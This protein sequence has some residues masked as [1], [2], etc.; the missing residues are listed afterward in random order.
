MA[1]LQTTANGQT[2][3]TLLCLAALFERLAHFVVISLLALHLNERRGYSEPDAL[4]VCGLYGAA[5]YVSAI[6]GGWVSDRSGNPRLATQIG[7]FLLCGGYV[8]LASP[9]LPIVVP[10]ALLTCGHALYKPSLAVLFGRLRGQSAEARFRLLY[11]TVNV[12]ATLA[13]FAAQL[14]L[15]RGGA[16]A[17]FVLANLLSVVTL[18]TVLILSKMPDSVSEQTASRESAQGHDKKTPNIG[19]VLILCLLSLAFFSALAQTEGALIFWARD[20]TDRSLLGYEIPTL[21][22]TCLPALCLLLIAAPIERLWLLLTKW[23]RPLSAQNKLRL[24]LLVTAVAFAMFALTAR[25]AETSGKLAMRNLVFLNLLLAV[26]ELC[27]AP[28]AM[29]IVHSISPG[30]RQG[31]GMGLWFLVVALANWLAGQLGRLSTDS[32]SA[33]PYAA[34]ALLALGLFVAWLVS[35][36]FWAKLDDKPDSVEKAEAGT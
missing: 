2:E 14:A 4:S 11:L 32:R 36:L 16:M 13:P 33:H 8:I 30:K 3:G 34:W 29:A 25:A 12:G 10:L 31:L 27:V 28:V 9:T 35:V 18:A 19:T 15:S 6:L 24:G 17:P 26:G 23:G 20:K 21:W 5:V 22:L 1:A 7:A